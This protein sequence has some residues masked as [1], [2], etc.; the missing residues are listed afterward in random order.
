[1]G[2]NGFV[3]RSE[4]EVDI[5][6]LC[7]AYLTAVLDYSKDCGKCNYCKT[8]FEEMLEVIQDISNGEATEEDMEFLTSATEAVV[9]SSKCSIG[10][11]GPL[12]FL[13]ALNYFADDFAQAG[14]GERSVSIGNYRSKI[15][16]PCIDAC[17]IHLDIPRYI[18]MIKDAKFADSLN[19]IRE[20]LPLPGLLGR[21][22]FRPCESQ[23]RRANLDEPIAIKSL[24]RFVADKELADEKQPVF[25]AT[26]SRKTG[27]V[28]IVGA[29]PAGITCAFHLALRG[30]KVTIYEKQA[31]PGGMATFGIPDYRVPRQILE[32]EVTHVVN[33]GVTIVYS[34]TVGKDVSI[35]QLEDEF[36]AVFVGIGANQSMKMGIEGEDQEYKGFIPGLV[37][38]SDINAGENPHAEGKNVVVIGGGNVAIDCV[39]SALRMGKDTVHLVYRRTRKEMPA[40]DAE[41]NDAEEEGVH[42]HYLTAPVLILD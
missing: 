19:V 12:P 25:Q 27:Q 11:I 24:K 14:R 26:P 40:D 28:A 37:Y 22:C 8:G 2:W 31:D 1:M 21:A 6:D 4:E 42:F 5:I 36:D 30:H 7:R 20:R 3:I 32:D 9:D 29:G 16:A 17:P 35:S 39:R 15:T 10:K 41:I 38:L 23:C 18:E 33:L 34:Q 13:Q